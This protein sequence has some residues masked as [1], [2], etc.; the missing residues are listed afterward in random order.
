[1]L[2]C[3]RALLA[4]TRCCRASRGLPANAAVAVYVC[5]SGKAGR[6]GGTC[7]G[8]SCAAEFRSARLMLTLHMCRAMVTCGLACG[9]PWRLGVLRDGSFD[10]QSDTYLLYAVS[11]AA[12]QSTEASHLAALLERRRRRLLSCDR[13]RRHVVHEGVLLG[14]V[15]ECLQV[16]DVDAH[17]AEGQHLQFVV[18]VMITLWLGDGMG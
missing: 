16:A 9:Q 17:V 12:L 11:K 15:A 1:M 8:G 14:A 18:R 2:A 3:L 7:G 6:N 5:L 4:S 13:E 10:H